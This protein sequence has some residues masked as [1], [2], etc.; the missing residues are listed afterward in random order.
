MNFFQG[1]KKFLFIGIIVVLL[2][3]IPL[4]VYFLQQ[5]QETRSRAQKATTLYFATPGTTTAA[6]SVQ[7][8]M[9][10][11]VPLDIIVDPGTNQVSFIKMSISYDPTKLSLNQTNG[12]KQND[13]SFPSVLEG[14]TFTDGN[15]SITLSIGADP[16]K[17]AQ[18]P[19]KVATLTFTA[20]D[21]TGTTPTQVKFMD[22]QTQVLSIA[23]SDQP[24]ENVLASTKPI[25]VTI[26]PS[27]ST[28]PAGP[29]VANQAPTCTSLSIDRTSSG[30]APLSLTFTANGRD[31]D[32]TISK[33][34]FNFGDGPVQDMT[35]SG[36]IGTNTV[37]IPAA[38]TYNNPG[39][40]QA[41][42]I[43]TDNVGAVSNSG[44]TQTITVTA[45]TTTGNNPPAAASQVPAAQPTATP[46]P[47]AVY[48]SAPAVP[49]PTIK[50]SGPGGT[51]VAGGVVAAIVSIVGAI[52]FFAL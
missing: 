9:G 30:P 49:T 13:V 7:K 4:T 36:G 18:S 1:S 31:S 24:S 38:H 23:Q 12:I 45:A 29:T 35:Q 44:C 16:T 6:A 17:V 39:T 46:V 21:T 15:V 25:S 27:Q 40:Y 50:A 5:N 28:T 33:A 14:P 48:T 37:S 8:N 51:V 43:L 19:T 10:E 2:A 3:A 42:A 11:S 34:T 26:Q 41:S 22:G 32:G 20:K 47:V 52:M